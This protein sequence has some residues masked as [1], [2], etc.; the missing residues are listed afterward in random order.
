MLSAL[1][2]LLGQLPSILIRW[3]HALFPASATRVRAC[4]Q[5]VA[6]VLGWAFDSL[7]LALYLFGAVFAG[8]MVL[9]VPAWGMYNRHDTVWLE[10]SKGEEDE[11]GEKKKE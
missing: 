8:V 6:Y 5:V 1:D 2:R 7:S 10:N 4:A 11:E 3:P 9:C